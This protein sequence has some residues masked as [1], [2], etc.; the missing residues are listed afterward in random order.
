MSDDDRVRWEERYIGAG[1]AALGEPERSIA[2]VPPANGIAWALDLACGRGRHC[3]PL[4]ARGYKVVAVDISST[5]LRSLGR[6]YASVRERL[7]TVQADLDHWPF[8]FDCFELVVKIDFLDR[9]LFPA[10]K[11]AVR[12]GGHVLVD[13]FA[14][15]DSASSG[16]R[17]RE[18]RL[19]PGE[20]ES[21]F[22]DWEILR[23]ESCATPTAREFIFA[24]RPPR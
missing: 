8:G 11:A 5:A 16:P 23:L 1:T 4:I 18:Y 14:R 9:R 15:D 12:P 2:V 19:G 22:T 21:A 7:C 17:R 6:T 20:L 24:R 3:G 10:I 13:G